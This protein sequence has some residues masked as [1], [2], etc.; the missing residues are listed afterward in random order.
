MPAA[1]PQYERWPLFDKQP[2]TEVGV[3]RNQV[4]RERT[5]TLSSC[6]PPLV[7]VQLAL[8]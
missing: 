3:P 8:R 1:M 4:G 6:A 7:R 2:R 5:Y